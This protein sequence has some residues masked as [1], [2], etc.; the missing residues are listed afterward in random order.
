MH[1]FS[2]HFFLLQSAFKEIS[3][4]KLAMPLLFQVYNDKL[5]PTAPPRP[6]APMPPPILEQC[7]GVLEFSAPDGQAYVPS[8]MLRNLKLRD[9]GSARFSTVKGVPPG[10]FVKFRPY[11]V[12]FIELAAAVGPRDLLEAA[13]RN[14][15][16]LTTGQRLVIDV[17]DTQVRAMLRVGATVESKFIPTHSCFSSVPS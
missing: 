12:S 7:C 9:G 17:A 14:Y 13:L 8:W 2:F 10:V 15:S 6:G 1:S 11:S 16:A 5:K 3:R 4:L